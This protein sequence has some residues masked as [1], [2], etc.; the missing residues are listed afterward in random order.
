MPYKQLVMYLLSLTANSTATED[1]DEKEWQA[2]CQVSKLQDPTPP[3]HR[4][5]QK[6][7]LTTNN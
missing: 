5:L 3:R 2:D 6:H 7:R 1:E 4:K